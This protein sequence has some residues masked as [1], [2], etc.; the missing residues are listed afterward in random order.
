[1]LF[2]FDSAAQ[3]APDI[4]VTDDA[5]LY[6]RVT[7][8]TL[9]A[10][11]LWRTDKETLWQ[12]VSTVSNTFTHQLEII[13]NSYVQ[14]ANGLN[15]AG[16]DGQY[17]PADPSFAITGTGAE[18]TGTAHHVQL[19]V[20]INTIGGIKASFPDGTLL[21]SHPLCFGY[22]DPV[23]GSSLVLGNIRNAIGWLVAS[24]QVVYS[25][26]FSGGIKASVSYQNNLAGMAQDLILEQTPARSSDLRALQLEPARTVDRIHRRHTRARPDCAYHPART[27]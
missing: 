1:M 18:A 15:I 20:N 23:D 12:T 16:P 19:P 10:Q 9:P 27:G 3:N 13:T 4:Q 5:V 17:R 6:E 14:I 8:S 21:E 25:N 11:A 2:S 26:C 7:V 22:Y 24:N